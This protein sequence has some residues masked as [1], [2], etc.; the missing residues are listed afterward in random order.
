[1]SHFELTNTRV[2]DAKGFPSTRLSASHANIIRFVWMGIVSITFI[3]CIAGL[4]VG[5]G[6]FQELCT[7]TTCHPLQLKPEQMRWNEALGLSLNFYAVYT[8]VTLAIFSGVCFVVGFMIFWY[9]PDNWM[10][11]YVS[12]FLITFGVGTVPILTSLQSIVP[13]VQWWS[14]LLWIMGG[15]SLPI[16]LY[17]FPN[18][19]FVSSWLRWLLL[20]WIIYNIV[21]LFTEPLPQAGIL[22]GPPSLFTQIAFVV[23]GLSQIYRY[24]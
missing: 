16:I 18:G 7:G 6:Q 11:L 1:M 5:F 15:W 13:Q 3:L 9:I 24:R 10:G 22:S 2:G 23:G 19:R 21:L 14:V 8:T 4:I 17:I 12:L 20:T